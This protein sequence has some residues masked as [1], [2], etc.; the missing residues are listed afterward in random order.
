MGLMYDIEDDWHSC[1]GHAG[2]ILI[3]IALWTAIVWVV[4]RAIR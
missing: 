2:S 1:V 3:S 4:S